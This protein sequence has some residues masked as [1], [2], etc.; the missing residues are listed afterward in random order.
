MMTKTQFEQIR[1]AINDEI[2]YEVYLKNNIMFVDDIEE[3]HLI[4]SWSRLNPQ[5]DYIDW[6]EAYDTH[7]QRLRHESRDIPF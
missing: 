6:R 3:K 1:E 5:P 7:Q 4:E 2:L